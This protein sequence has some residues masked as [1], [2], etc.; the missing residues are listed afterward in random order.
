[1]FFYYECWMLARF[2]GK[3]VLFLGV[4]FVNT[5]WND[6]K[7]Q[8]GYLTLYMDK[9]CRS[10]SHLQFQCMSGF[11]S[12]VCLLLPTEIRD[13]NQPS[14]THH[15]RGPQRRRKILRRL[16]VAKRTAQIYIYIWIMGE[17]WHVTCSIMQRSFLKRSSLLSKL[18]WKIHS[19][20]GHTWK[21]HQ[22]SLLLRI[23]PCV[24]QSSSGSMCR[25][26]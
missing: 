8:D 17:K 16:R 11:P 6:N 4:L 21:S 2:F 5:S 24:R 14:S 15:E 20:F 10:R 13:G 1:M 25:I 18:G 23:W 9:Q 12:L 7:N 19:T 3:C 22:I 26:H